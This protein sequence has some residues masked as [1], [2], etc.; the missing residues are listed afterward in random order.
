VERNNIFIKKNASYFKDFKKE[1]F[2]IEDMYRVDMFSIIFKANV[3][4]FKYYPRQICLIPYETL[5]KILSLGKC[6]VVYYDKKYKMI[7]RQLLR[8]VPCSLIIEEFI[9]ILSLLELKFKINNYF[10]R[11]PSEKKDEKKWQI[12]FENDLKDEECE[13]F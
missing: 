10:V 12:I 9:I 8:Y 6:E 4:Y 11:A 7:D 5:M 1:S 13:F 3:D 2:T